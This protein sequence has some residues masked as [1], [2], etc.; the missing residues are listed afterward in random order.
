MKYRVTLEALPDAD[1][2]D[3]VVRN[4]TVRHDEETWAL[5]YAASAYMASGVGRIEE[6]L[7]KT[8]LSVLEGNADDSDLGAL[9]DDFCD[10]ARAI[11]TYWNKHDAKLQENIDKIHRRLDE[12]SH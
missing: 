12:Q 5:A 11:V 4:I 7:A 2:G 8:V 10:S 6:Y 9:Q 3:Q 1:D